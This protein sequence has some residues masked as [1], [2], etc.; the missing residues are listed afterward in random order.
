MKIKKIKIIESQ[1]VYD[2]E[3]PKY[4]NFALENGVIVHNCS[5]WSLKTLLNEGLNGVP[6]KI[7]AKAPKNLS[8]AIGQMVNF[9]GCFTEDTVIKTK[10][11]DY[12]IRELLDTCRD[13]FDILSY[14]EKTNSFVEAKL[15]NLHK[16]QE[17]VETISLTFEDGFICECTLDHKFLTEN[18]GW[19]EAKDLNTEDNII[20]YKE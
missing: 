11:G 19:V 17:N 3:V 7:S 16:T 15:K 6:G 20:Q 18:R 9:L 13:S 14:D 4:H 8:A 1:D 5:G 12:T 2:I 10:E